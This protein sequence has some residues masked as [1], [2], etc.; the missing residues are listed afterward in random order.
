L[1][2][3]SQRVYWGIDES[4]TGKWLRLSRNMDINRVRSPDTWVYTS[5]RWVISSGLKV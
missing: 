3:F 4:G 5:R 1:K 2:K